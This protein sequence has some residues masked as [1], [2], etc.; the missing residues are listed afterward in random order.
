VEEFR[1]TTSSSLGF[2]VRDRTKFQKGMDVSRLLSKLV[3]SDWALDDLRTFAALSGR[4]LASRHAA[5]VVPGVT[6]PALSSIATAIGGREQ[7]FTAE[8]RG[9][10]AFY[11]PLVLDDHQRF[12]ALLRS[13]GPLLG[14][15]TSSYMRAQQ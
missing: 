2:R 6:E 7:A 8:M 14:I 9:F 13:A 4:L 1:L 3:E 5:G 11:G 12:V 10:I 15:R